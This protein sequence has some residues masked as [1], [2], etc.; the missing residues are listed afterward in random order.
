MAQSLNA[1]NPSAMK[2]GKLDDIRVILLLSEILN[3][4]F[5]ETLYFIDCLKFMCFYIYFIHLTARSKL[6]LLQIRDPRIIAVISITKVS[7]NLY[8]SP[9]TTSFKISES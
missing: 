2:T 9:G 8:F 7:K 3:N 4:T 1:Q 6:F 5:L